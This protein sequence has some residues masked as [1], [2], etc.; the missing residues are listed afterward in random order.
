MTG[1]RKIIRNLSGKIMPIFSTAGPVRAAAMALAL[2]LPLACLPNPKPAV[3]THTGHWAVRSPESLPID[4]VEYTWTFF[5]SG[6]H[7]RLTG[8]IRNN[9]GQAHQSVSLELTLTDERGKAVAKGQT[10]VFPAYL[11]PGSEGEFELVSLASSAGR[12]L[13]AG[14]LLT[15]AR[16]FSR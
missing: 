10:H 9:S 2:A 13:P 4:V 12:N 14:R 15:T 11:P 7:V 6:R 1:A 3:P 8:R 5:N 16:T